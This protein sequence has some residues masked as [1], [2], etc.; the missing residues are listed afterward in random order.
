[1]RRISSLGYKNVKDD[2]GRGDVIIDID[3]SYLIQKVFETYATG[4]FTLKELR[5]NVLL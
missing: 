4:S 5:L 1:M 3:R 2:R